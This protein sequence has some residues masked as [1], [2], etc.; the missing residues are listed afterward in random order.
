MFTHRFSQLDFLMIALMA[1]GCIIVFSQQSK[2]NSILNIICFD[3]LAD[4]SL[5]LYVSH[6]SIRAC[7]PIIMPNSSYWEKLL[8][9]IVCSI[10]YALLILY[11]VKSTQKILPWRKIKY[12]FVESDKKCM[13]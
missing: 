10:L 3:K 13:F 7:I 1:V 11:I 9:Y 12:C 2:L 8:P 4:Y 6:W 5:A